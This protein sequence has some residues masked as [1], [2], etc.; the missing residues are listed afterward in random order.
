MVSLILSLGIIVLIVAIG[1][2][3]GAWV[4]ESSRVVDERLIILVCFHSSRLVLR[5]EVLLVSLSVGPRALGYGQ[6]ER[7][8]Q[9]H[10][11]HK[12]CRG[13]CI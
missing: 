13:I 10:C 4:S 2:V 6:R 3:R 11:G 9:Q 1:T 5:L 8:Q 12:Y 7:E